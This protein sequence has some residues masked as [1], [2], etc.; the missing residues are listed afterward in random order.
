[1]KPVLLAVCSALALA[2]CADDYYG[3]DNY[4]Y[5]YGG[6]NGYGGYAGY[7]Y[8]GGYYGGGLVYYDGYYGPYSGGYWGRDGYYYYRPRSGL[9]Y[10]R[11]E[12]RHF[13][14]DYANGYRRYGDNRAYDR[15]RRDRDRDH[16]WDR[17]RYGR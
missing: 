13:R 11:D 6:Y 7:P 9:P 2:A 16:D 14:R 17:D 15:Y 4:G 1:M 5:G 12:G 10:A 8:S 3:Y